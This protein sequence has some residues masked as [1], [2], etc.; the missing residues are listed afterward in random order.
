MTTTDGTLDNFPLE[1]LTW[2]EEE[3]LSLLAERQTNREI[4][5]KLCISL[6]TVKWYNKRLYAKLGAKN[7]REAA[8]RA[9]A[10]GL[11]EAGDNEPAISTHNLP[12]QTT[13]FVGRQRELED[14]SELLAQKDTRLVTILAPGGMGK[15]RLALKAAEKQVSHYVDGVFFVPIT[16]L[17]SEDHLASAIAESVGLRLQ[18]GGNPRQQVLQYF[19]NR[20]ILLLLDNFE[21]ALSGAGLVGEMLHTA[22]ETK[23]LATSRERLNLSGE[24]IYPLGGLAMPGTDISRDAPDKQGAVELFIQSARHLCPAFEAQADDWD[25][26]V[27]ICQIVDGMPLGIVLAATWIRV[28]SPPEIASEITKD[29]DILSTDLR[30][31]PQRQRSIR[32][33]FTSTWRRLSDMARMTFEKLSMFRGGFTLEA[34]QEIAAANLPTIQLLAD[35]GILQRKSTGRYELHELLRQFAEEKLQQG[36][37]FRSAYDAHSL[38]YAELLSKLETELRSRRQTA[39]L[40]RIEDDIENVQAAWRHALKQGNDTTVAMMLPSLYYFY[41]TRGWFE[42]GEATFRMAASH[43]ASKR[44]TDEQTLI[45]G[46]LFARQGAFAHRL[47]RY[48]KA[49][50]VLQASLSILRNTGAHEELAFT[51]SFMADLAR[52]RGKYEASKQLC[53][54]SLALFTEVDDKWGI[55]GELHNLGVAA[56]HLG[57]FGE[58]QNY[59]NESLARSKELDDPYGIVTSLIGIGVLAHDLGNYQDAEQLYAESLEISGA[60]DDRYGVAAS[61][62]NLGRIYYLTGDLK[63]GRQRCQTGLEICIELGDRWGTAAALINLGDIDCKLERF[64]ESKA[65]FKEALQIVTEL[66]SEPLTV[67][68]L[69]GMVALLAETGNEESALELLAHILTHPPDDKEIRERADHLRDRLQGNLSQATVIE[70]QARSSDKSIQTTVRQLFH[71]V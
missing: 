46:R 7:R 11:L 54:E 50:Q 42:E 5:Q 23:V 19:R 31:F 43:F 36:E 1:P 21:R 10:L 20:Q 71:L 49:A 47:G 27:Q 63:A 29:L 4:A 67:E 24:T 40:S 55:A 15:T 58:A 18:P 25:H 28:L 6:E 38:Y 35:R 56:Y 22:P 17:G 68:I 12:A 44:R 52:S 14:L 3:I 53:R 57:D 33:V 9:V 39:A 8:A 70:I 59:Y 62:I 37:G 45:L 13:P 41:E 61:L 48:E 2:R 16:E 64:Q 66:K 34:A 60:L 69:V 32:A 30:D 51:L 26:V 65:Y